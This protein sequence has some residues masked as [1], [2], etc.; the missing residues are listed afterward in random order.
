[1]KFPPGTYDIL[2]AFCFVYNKIYNIDIKGYEK[3]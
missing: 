2:T 3:A 1:M